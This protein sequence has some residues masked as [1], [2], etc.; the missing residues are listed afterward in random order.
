MPPPN[1]D[2]PNDPVGTAETTMAGRMG[3]TTDNK[4]A[5][6]RNRHREAALDHG[7][8]PRP[9]GVPRLPSPFLPQPNQQSCIIALPSFCAATR[10]VLLQ[11]S[12]RPTAAGLRVLRQTAPSRYGMRGLAS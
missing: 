7:Q 3:D 12:S 2:W 6:G 4:T 10:K 5:R 11:S 1:T 9:L 8:S